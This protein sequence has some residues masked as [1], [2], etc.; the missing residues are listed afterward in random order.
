MDFKMIKERLNKLD[1]ACIFDSNKNLRVMDPGI[2]PINQ[3]I[4]MIGMARTVQCQGDFLTII[5]ALYEAKEDE[6]LVIDGGAEKIALAGELF[7][8]E[9]QRKKL[10]G[11]VIDGGCRDVNQIRK[12]HFP[13]FAR[14]ITPKPGTSS[15]IFST[16]IEINCGGIPV[17]P[18]DIL[19]G[20]DDGIIVMNDEEVMGIV[21]IAESIQAKEE[22]IASRLKDGESFINMLNFSEHYEKISKNQESKLIFTV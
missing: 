6:V 2:K 16:Q 14:Y 12:T 20:D 15:K 10:S 1:A 8:G 3:G 4:K 13:V 7:T 21:E 18:G 5:K 17:A 9:A 19:F 22:K 11:I